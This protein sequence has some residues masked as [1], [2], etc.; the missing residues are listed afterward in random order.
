MLNIVC[1]K[2]L[3]KIRTRCLIILFW[4][5]S[6]SSSTINVVTSSTSAI[7][8]N[9][10]AEF[11]LAIGWKDAGWNYGPHG[12]VLTLWCPGIASGFGSAPSL[13]C[14]YD[15]PHTV[16]LALPFC[17]YPLGLYE[18]FGNI[19]L[20]AIG[21][22]CF[23]SRHWNSWQICWQLA[24]LPLPAQCAVHFGKR[25]LWSHDSLFTSFF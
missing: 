4:E 5:N 11:C 7:L 2:V 16:S 8:F 10:T 17:L 18:C 15:L 23:L 20:V 14:L 9:S 3:S 24:A 21:K 19:P 22:L 13:F 25:H 12:L 1:L 6:T